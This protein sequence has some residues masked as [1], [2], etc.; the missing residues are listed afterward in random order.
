MCV[1]RLR[2]Q[3]WVR[4]WIGVWGRVVHC[5]YWDNHWM[6]LLARAAK[7]DWRGKRNNPSHPLH[8]LC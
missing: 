3:V 5:T 7:D 1:L 2:V 6:Y 8:K 4:E